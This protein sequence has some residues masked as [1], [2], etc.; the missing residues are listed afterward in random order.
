MTSLTALNYT[1]H[2]HT[3]INRHTCI[4]WKDG[5]YYKEEEQNYC[6][7]PPGD[8]DNVGGPWCYTNVVP[9]RW[10]RCNIPVC[11]G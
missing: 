8:S 6:R 3:T 1:G 11:R 7:T 2:I 4:Y 9:K 5:T 10:E